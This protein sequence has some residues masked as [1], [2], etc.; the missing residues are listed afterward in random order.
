MVDLSPALEEARLSH[1]RVSARAR[2]CKQSVFHHLLP[3]QQLAFTFENE[4]RAFPRAPYVIRMDI[5]DEAAPPH[6][7]S[8]FA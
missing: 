8:S 7:G 1:F 6:G 5:I 4:I 2:Q 3:A